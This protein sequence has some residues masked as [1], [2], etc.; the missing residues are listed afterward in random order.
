MVECCNAGL[1]ITYDDRNIQTLQMIPLFDLCRPRIT[2]H[3]QRRNDQDLADLEGLQHKVFD[4]RK[5][6]DFFPQLQ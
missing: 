1:C 2:G 3:T 5:G 6:Y 4:S